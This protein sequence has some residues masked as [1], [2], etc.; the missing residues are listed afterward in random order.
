[1]TR[2]VLPER[3]HREYREVPTV[4][5]CVDSIIRGGRV[6]ARRRRAARAGGAIAAVAAGVLA[7]G[8]GLD[9]V[10]RPGT[11]AVPG[12]SPSS[13]ASAPVSV[14]CLAPARIAGCEDRIRSWASTSAGKWSFRQSGMGIMPGYG[15]GGWSF[16]LTRE[17]PGASD[18]I[19][20][21]EITLVP[22]TVDPAAQFP[23][24]AFV[25]GSET[26]SDGS[27][28]WVSPMASTTH[29][30][31]TVLQGVDGERASVVILLK[32]DDTSVSKLEPGM[33]PLPTGWDKDVFNLL[34]DLIAGH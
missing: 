33:A 27:R 13:T 30:D 31:G 11:T 21:L 9:L 25:R 26:L 32:A 19:E 2:D 23:D 15:P 7:L 22:E 16:E 29:I 20:H 4:D 8:P 5:F 24:L 3:V 34:N 28:T 12:G 6:R 14:G 10:D 18:I 17:R 1:M